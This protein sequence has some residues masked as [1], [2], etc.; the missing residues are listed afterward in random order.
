MKITTRCD[1]ST[2][3]EFN[4]ALWAKAV[5]AR[6]VRTGKVRAD[7]TVVS[8][9]VEYSTDS[10]L[11]AHAVSKI[12]KLVRRIQTAGGAR[13][14]RFRDRS[15]AAVTRVRAIGSKL[16]LRMAAA[17]DEAKAAVMRLTGGTGRPGRDHLGRR[18]LGTRQRPP[19]LRRVTGRMRRRLV[20]AV[21]E[22]AATVERTRRVVAQ[23]RRR[24]AGEVLAAA[25]RLV[26]LHGPDARPIAKGRL[27]KPVEI[28]YKAQVVDNEDDIVLE[29]TPERG[30][31]ADAPQLARRSNGLPAASA[32]SQ[33]PSPLTAAM[34]RPPSTRR[35]TT[36]A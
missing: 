27:G 1:E 5:A 15:G 30:N 35:C 23:T 36:S 22:L 11:L 7:T 4:E 6:V 24:I 13:R 3:L 25:T 33:P 20:R 19:G 28:G 9:N 18:L 31:P 32:K 16:R 10:A 29:H 12:T 2:V 26:S 21:N 8:A 14:T 17:K 34:V